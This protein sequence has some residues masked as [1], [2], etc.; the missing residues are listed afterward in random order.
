MTKY[1]LV[2]DI[3]SAEE[4]L[5]DVLQHI[6]EKAPNA[7]IVGTGDIFECTISKKKLPLKK[8]KRFEDVF[9][10]SS[11]FEQM[12]DFPTVYG[13]QEERILLTST[14]GGELRQWMEEL[15]ETIEL[16]KEAGIIH[17]HQWTWG[18]TPWGLQKASPVARLTFF[19]HSHTSQAFLD[20]SLQ[21]II[22]ERTM[23]VEEGEW[24]IN[25]GSVVDHREWV[26][27]DEAEQTITF[28]KA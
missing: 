14:G 7:Q 18:G 22:F 4:E 27:Y 16:N 6:K 28:M 11:S 26:L 23:S 20:G 9:L 13:N 25:V 1:A 8:L 21:E 12:I 10:T 5:T 24:L 2:G 3:H 17:S 19:G 15:P